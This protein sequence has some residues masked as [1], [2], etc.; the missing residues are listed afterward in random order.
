[1]KE[2]DKFVYQVLFTNAFITKSGEEFQSFFSKIINSAYPSRFI[3]TRPCGRIGDKKSDG[4]I[5]EDNTVYQVYAPREMGMAKTKSKM[6]DDFYGAL[7]KWG[8]QMKE[9][10]FVDNEYDG[11][12]VYVIDAMNEFKNIHPE[13][14][15]RHMGYNELKDVLFG[16]S[17]ATIKQILGPI[18]EG[19]P[20]GKP[21]IISSDYWEIIRDLCDLMFL[22]HFDWWND[23][24]MR[25]LLW[26]KLVE[27]TLELYD[28]KMCSIWPC[29]DIELENNIRDLI[30]RFV[31]YVNVFMEHSFLRDDSF[32]GEDKFYKRV[33]PNPEYYNDLEK[34]KE[35]EKKWFKALNNYVFVL[36]TFI[37]Y[38]NSNY[39]VDIIAL[40]KKKALIDS[41]GVYSGVPLVEQHFYPKGIME[42]E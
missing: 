42:I 2:R 24:A 30:D 32:W 23:H 12:P 31:T 35:W 7:E 27:N 9:W 19:E 22:D 10:V 17:D 21:I 26:N 37:Q 29:T 11:T 6:T 20:E 18:P 39:T 34:Y 36:N 41:M 1:M 5:L 3:P 38:I 25:G 33:F 8:S 28:L 4:Y 15:F 40:K 13:I 14:H 16:C